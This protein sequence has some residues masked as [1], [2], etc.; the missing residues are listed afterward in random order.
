MPWQSENWAAEAVMALAS[1]TFPENPVCF[2]EQ[3]SRSSSA[4]QLLHIFSGKKAEGQIF[5]C[6]FSE[7]ALPLL[8]V[9]MP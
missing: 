3:S 2:S 1:L 8:L 6:T 5:F 9:Y 4:K 7:V